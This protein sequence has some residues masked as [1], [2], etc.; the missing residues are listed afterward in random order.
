MDVAFG[1]VHVVV[2]FLHSRLSAQHTDFCT[3][4]IPNAE[5]VVSYLCQ[6]AEASLQFLQFLSQQKLFRERLIRNKEL[7]G[8]GVL[9]LVQSIL[10]LNISPNSVRSSTVMASISRLKAKVL[11]ILLHLSLDLAKSVALEILELLKS[12]LS[13]DPK[14]F[15]ATSDRTHPM[16]LLQLNAMRLADAFSDDSNFRSHITVSF[17]EFLSAIFSLSWR[18]F[19]HVVFC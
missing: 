3:K 15:S 6:Q 9:F 7:C 8:N 5:A 19:I 16:G 14:H 10:K 1:A 11:S 18:F 17:T 12:G 4:S 2:R 13:K